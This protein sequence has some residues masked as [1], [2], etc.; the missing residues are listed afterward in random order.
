MS[1]EAERSEP[2]M[3]VLFELLRELR[4]RAEA[5]IQS[6]EDFACDLTLF[7]ELSFL[8]MSFP[9]ILRAAGSSPSCKHNIQ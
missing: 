4:P 1:L 7:Q 6:A 3:G 9:T 5:R 8:I 2:A